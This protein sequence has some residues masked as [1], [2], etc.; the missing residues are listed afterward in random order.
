MLD[1]GCVSGS[2]SS[3]SPQRGP[4]ASQRMSLRDLGQRDR[5]GLQRAAQKADRILGGLRFE[6]IASFA[7]RHAGPVS[8]LRNHGGGEP[9]R[10]VK[11]GAD[12]R[13][14]QRQFVDAFQ[15]RHERVATQ[16]STCAAYP[17]NS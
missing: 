11:P 17:L 8:E 9:G 3:P 1:P 7:K 10:R 6:M 5:V 16:F 15:R 12:R 4:D 2:F 14:S 13:A